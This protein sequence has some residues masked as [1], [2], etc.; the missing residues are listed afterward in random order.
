VTVGREVGEI[1]SLISGI[2]GSTGAVQFVELALV[3]QCH[4]HIRQCEE[5]NSCRLGSFDYASERPRIEFSEIEARNGQVALDGK[6]TVPCKLQ[7]FGTGIS[8]LADQV[9]GRLCAQKVQ[10]VLVE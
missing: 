7:T 2:I 8:N 9:R 3:L 1:P 10:R 4:L 5:A 6:A